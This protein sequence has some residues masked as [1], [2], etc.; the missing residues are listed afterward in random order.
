[1]KRCLFTLSFLVLALGAWAAN[2]TWS[3]AGSTDY[4]VAGN[5]SL[6]H[7]PTVGE[8]AYFDGTSVV[9]C[10]LSANVAPDAITMVAAYTGT[11]DIGVYNM[12]V[13]GDASFAGKVTMGISADAGLT[14]VNFTLNTG[15]IFTCSGNSKISLSG[16]WTKSAGTFTCGTST[17][18]FN[19]TATGKT[20]TSGASNSPFYAVQFNGAGGGW[21]LQDPLVATMLTHTAGTLN[22]NAKNVTTTG[23]LT[24]SDGA[25]ITA[26]GLAG[27]TITVGGAFSAAGHAG[28]LLTLNPAS[29]WTLN[30]TGAATANYVNVANCNASGGSPV[31]ATN[32]DPY[33]RQVTVT[34]TLSP[35]A[36][37]IYTASGIYTTAYVTAPYYRRGMDNYYI[38][39]YDTGA[40]GWF[41]SSALGNVSVPRWSKTGASIAGNTYY[42]YSTTVG[43]ATVANVVDSGKV[44]G[45][46][47][48]THWIFGSL[49]AIISHHRRQM[50]GN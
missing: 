38:W 29:A 23:N 32:S 44:G 6:G 43:T 13:A 4:S 10:T 16:N 1:M 46:G 8:T 5:W 9:D 47:G 24:V 27:S 40:N 42:P 50:E 7:V 21:T 33:Y 17:V 31:M 26:A 48:N 18:I 15:A 3:S 30:V 49:A 45:S 41:I 20:I 19:S 36:T 35:D 11:L 34:G 28:A 22:P 14:C 25:L 2:N 39:R 37:G 12:A